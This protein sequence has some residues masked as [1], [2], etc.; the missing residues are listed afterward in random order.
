MNHESTIHITAH[1][2]LT[3]CFSVNKRKKLVWYI[4]PSVRDKCLVK[5]KE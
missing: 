4:D 1:I 5:L 2:T 3:T